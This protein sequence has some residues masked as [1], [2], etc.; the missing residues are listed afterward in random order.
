MAIHVINP[1]PA[2][3]RIEVIASPRLGTVNR[4]SEARP[5]AG[6]KGMNVARGIR[7]L[8]GEASVYGPLGGFVGEFIRAACVE[9]GVVDRHVQIAGETRICTILVDQATHQSTVINEPGPVLSSREERLL[10]ESVLERCASGDIVIM[11][12]SLARGLGDRFYAQL[13]ENV[14]ALGAQAIVDTSGRPLEAALKARPWMA[15]A[16]ARELEDVSRSAV[17]IGPEWTVTT[18]GRAG[19]T[20]ASAHGQWRVAVPEVEVVNATGAGDAFLAGLASSLSEG[21]SLPN[22]L[23]LGAACATGSVTTLEP[24]IPEPEQ[25]VRLMEAVRVEEV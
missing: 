19:A 15:K 12:G 20:A 11:T 3:D 5:I 21:D 24:Y 25:L 13:V 14:Q 1:N 2:M 10:R 18:R 16:N 7:Q 17:V 22:A 9:L 4:S 6:G 8:G 23:R